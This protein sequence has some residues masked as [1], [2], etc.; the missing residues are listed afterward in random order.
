MTQQ[1]VSLQSLLI[2]R[3]NFFGSEFPETGIDSVR[4][5]PIAKFQ[6]QDVSSDNALDAGKL[7]LGRLEIAQLDND[8]NFPDHGIINLNMEGGA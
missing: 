1:Q 4:R 7:E 5:G 2:F 3:F 8:P 6:R